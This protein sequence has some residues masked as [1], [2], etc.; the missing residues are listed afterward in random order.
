[1]PLSEEEIITCKEALGWAVP[2]LLGGRKQ[3]VL[4]FVAQYFG[5]TAREKLKQGMRVN[6]P[7]RIEAE[8]LLCRALHTD[9]QIVHPQWQRE[10]RLKRRTHWG[11]TLVR[12]LSGDP[13]RY[14][15]RNL[16]LH[17][18][19]ALLSGLTG[20][21]VLWCDQLRILNKQERFT[22]RIEALGQA[23]RV[24]G[25]FPDLNKFDRPAIDRIRHC[26]DGKNLAYALTRLNE[27]IR[28]PWRDTDTDHF[29]ELLDEELG[30]TG[31]REQGAAVAAP[32]FADTTCINVNTVLEVLA[33]LAIAK[34]LNDE[35]WEVQASDRWTPRDALSLTKEGYTATIRKGFTNGVEDRTVPYLKAVGYSARG[36]QPD[37]VLSFTSTNSSEISYFLGDAKRNIANDE[38][39]AYC[40]GAFFA[41]LTDMIAYSHVLKINLA[42]DAGF[43]PDGW[44]GK[45]PK[46]ML[47]FGAM[48]PRESQT[49][50]ELISGFSFCEYKSLFRCANHEK[51]KSVRSQHFV[52]TIRKIVEAGKAE[53]HADV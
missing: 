26:P 44:A 36:K 28:A 42:T 13:G 16:T 46:G 31:Q 23:S 40:R 25:Q 3:N 10:T 4:T 12:H 33:T 20:L 27:S 9:P 30:G 6:D 38:N 2:T 7:I 22:A 15:N 52:E 49:N 35:G 8:E 19:T 43:L 11:K 48:R 5:D 53:L 51:S 21:A 41:I 37:I 18:D 47:F 45:A 34:V 1:M 50:G 39:Y 29:L 14:E 32:F 17:P 24:S